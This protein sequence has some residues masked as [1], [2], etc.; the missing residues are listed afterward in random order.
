[1]SL[2]IGIYLCV[3]FPDGAVVKN[4]LVSAGDTRDPVR[5][6]CQEDSREGNGTPLQYSCLKNSLD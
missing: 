5:S 6:V 2:E 3:G 4:P 1:M